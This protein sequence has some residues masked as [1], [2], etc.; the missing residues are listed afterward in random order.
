M[1]GEVTFLMP[2]EIPN[3]T[4]LWW[5]LGPTSCRL[6]MFDIITSDM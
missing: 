4:E 2:N 3:F 5:G 1:G 6:Y